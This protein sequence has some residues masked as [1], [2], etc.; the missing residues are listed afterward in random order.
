M[1]A[2]AAGSDLATVTTQPGSLSTANSQKQGFVLLYLR[3]VLVREANYRS[4]V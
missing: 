4:G 1:D 2:A 3:A